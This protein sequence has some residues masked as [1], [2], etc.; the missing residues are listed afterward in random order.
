MSLP[1]PDLRRVAPRPP[2]VALAGYALAAR[3]VDKGR[4][5]IA[6]TVGEYHYDCPLDR[7]FFAFAGV[8]ASELRE[9]LATGADD[10][11]VEHWLRQQAKPRP[12]WLR[13]LWTTLWRCNPLFLVMLLDDTIHTL[14][15]RRG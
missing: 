11:A 5:E 3:A 13:T 14:R 4:A 8:S 10:A 6:G 2:Q 12:A 1:A 15:G 9:L 7:R